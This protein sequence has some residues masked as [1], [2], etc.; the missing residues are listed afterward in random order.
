MVELAHLCQEREQPAGRGG[1]H[2]LEKEM[3]G[4]TEINEYRRIFSYFHNAVQRNVLKLSGLVSFIQVPV[5][6]FAQLEMYQ[7]NVTCTRRQ[8]LLPSCSVMMKQGT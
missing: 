6:G 7:L 2:R 1:E 5:P 8:Q 4:S 3:G